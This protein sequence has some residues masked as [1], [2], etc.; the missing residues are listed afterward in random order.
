MAL[1]D[2]QLMAIQHVFLARM[3]L[4]GYRRIQQ[5]HM[6]KLFPFVFVPHIHFGKAEAAYLHHGLASYIM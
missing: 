6:Y 1:K 3:C 2:E 5:V 4:Y